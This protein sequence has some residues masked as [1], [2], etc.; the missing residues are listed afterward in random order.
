MDKLENFWDS[1][2]NTQDTRIV[3]QIVMGS[4]QVIEDQN[5]MHSSNLAFIA[6]L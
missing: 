3:I 5:N 1:M 4:I 6:L 2:L